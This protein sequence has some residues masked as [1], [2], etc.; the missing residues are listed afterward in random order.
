[1]VFVCADLGRDRKSNL[2]LTDPA[3]DR[4]FT[5]VADSGWKLT[6]TAVKGGAKAGT[7]ETE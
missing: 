3:R 4:M 1:M 7:I 2:L 5:G 6:G